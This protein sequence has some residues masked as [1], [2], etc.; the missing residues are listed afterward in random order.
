MTCC[1]A[2]AQDGNEMSAKQYMESQ[3]APRRTPL[4]K[5]WGG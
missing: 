2:H 4:S 1:G 3:L 5:A